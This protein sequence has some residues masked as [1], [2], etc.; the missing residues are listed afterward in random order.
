MDYSYCYLDE[1]TPQQRD[2]VRFVL[3]Y[4][5]LIPGPKNY[6]RVASRSV[7]GM[8]DLKVTLSDGYPLGLSR[9]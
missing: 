9:K 6:S 5:P 8:V 4:S 7:D 1:F 2:R 3:Q